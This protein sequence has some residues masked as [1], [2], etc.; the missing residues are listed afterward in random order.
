MIVFCG[1]MHCRGEFPH[2]EAGVEF[3]NWFAGQD[4][5]NDENI[6]I[7]L[8]D[9]THGSLISGKVYREVVDWFLNKLKFKKIIILSGNHDYNRRSKSSSIDP[10]S[11]LP[12]VEIYDNPT[13]LSIVDNGEE[14]NMLLL[15]YYYSNTVDLPPMKQFYEN[16]PEE[17]I[18]RKWDYILGHY[19]DETE[20][21]FGDYIDTSKLKGKRILGH[22]HFPRGNYI[23]TPIITRRDER[24]NN[25]R[26]LLHEKGILSTHSTPRF[27]DY[28]EVKY[29][30]SL[31]EV[32]AMF[33]IWDIVDAP[34]ES[35]VYELYSNGV[36]IRKI[37]VKDTNSITNINEEDEESVQEKSISLHLDDFFKKS[38]Y[39][40]NVKQKVMEIMN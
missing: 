3:M 28:Y 15:P 34:N 32:E 39:G 4:F 23:G 36:T 14:L 6:M 22:I 25:N 16:L 1:D 27:L 35:A 38:N 29:P 24:G 9:V 21:L 7:H 26:I 40:N 5:N 17:W 12:N 2:F 11:V 37:T 18:E 20:T 33:P 30:N 19:N 10:L 31:F 13:N 8:G